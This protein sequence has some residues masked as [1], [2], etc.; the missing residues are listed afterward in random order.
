MLVRAPTDT[1]IATAGLFEDEKE[2]RCSQQAVDIR[3]LCL[4]HE[5]ADTLIVLHCIYTP[6]DFVLIA[7][8]YID[9]V[10]LLC[11]QQHRFSSKLVYVTMENQRYLNIGTLA[12]IIGCQMCDSLLIFDSLAGYDTASYLYGIGR[13][14]AIKTLE[15]NYCMPQA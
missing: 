7:A 10:V 13:P 12:G 1:L 6:G 14:N 8:R 2:V 5:E 3:D 11:A 15:E 9:I 4:T